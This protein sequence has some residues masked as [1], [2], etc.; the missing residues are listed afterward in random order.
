MAPNSLNLPFRF[1]YGAPLR[2]SRSGCAELKEGS[3]GDYVDDMEL[4]KQ[5]AQWSRV[6]ARRGAPD[7]GGYVCHLIVIIVA[8]ELRREQYDLRHRGKVTKVAWWRREPASLWPAA[9]DACANSSIWTDAA[10]PTGAVASDFLPCS[11]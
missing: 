2:P 1:V 8:A 7:N 4:G 5:A 6:Q 11:W 3:N 10:L 9:R